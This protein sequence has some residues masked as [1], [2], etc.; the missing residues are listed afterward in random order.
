[1]ADRVTQDGITIRETRGRTAN[2]SVDGRSTAERTFLCQGDPDPATCIQALKDSSILIDTY[3][4]LVRNAISTDRVGPEAWELTVSYD[5]LEPEVGDYKIMLGGNN[6]TVVQT[7]A[8]AQQ[9]Y[10]ASGETA[11]DFGLAIDVQDGVPQGVEVV[12]PGTK[13]SVIAKIASAYVTS[14]AAY[15]KL[16]NS[17]KGKTNNAVFLG[18]AAGELKFLDANGPLVDDD[19]KLTFD[20]ELSE[21]VTGYSI[22]NITGIDK[23]GHDYLWILHKKGVDATTKL[24]T[25]TP[26]AAYVARVHQEADMSVLKIGVS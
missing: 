7:A 2:D 6:G 20:F 26:R 22:G 4:G 3:E 23:K 1:M 16:I 21:N 19:P 13:I 11:P 12:V 5:A 8:F 25:S 14:P 15:T 18:F 17:L 9:S 10:P 24:P